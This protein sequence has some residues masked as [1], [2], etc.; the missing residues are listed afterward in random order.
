ME[1]ITYEMM[2]NI[3]KL[4]DAG[5][6]IMSLNASGGSSRSGV[7]LQMKADILGIPV[8]RLGNDEAGTIGGI[9]LT[10]KSIHVYESL[11]QA[12]DILVKPLRIYE[13]RREMHERYWVHYQRYRKLYNA[14]RPLMDFTE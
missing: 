2:I 10:G 11:E 1:G 13:P 14:V 3:E 6:Q 4:A 5:V 9:M 7:W 12:A 8:V